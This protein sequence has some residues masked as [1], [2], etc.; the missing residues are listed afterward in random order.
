MI[1]KKY[2]DV[3]VPL[4]LDQTFV[5]EMPAR[6]EELWTPGMRVLVPF[7]RKRLTGY[8]LGDHPDKPGFKTREILELLDDHPLFPENQIPF[9]EWIA[10]YYIHPLGEVIKTA[11]PGG[12]DRRDVSCAFM[13]EKGERALGSGEAGPDEA[14]V[15]EQFKAREG[16]RLT[17]LSRSEIGPSVLSLV[18]KMEK[19]GWIE[20]SAILKKENVRAKQEKYILC[21][22]TEPDPSV[23]MSK[24]RREILNIV[25][26]SGEISLTGLRAK[27]PTAPKLIRPLEQAGLIKIELRRVFRDPLGDPVEPDVPPELTREQALVLEKV[28]ADRD[29]GF[30]PYV[31]AGVTGSGKTEVYMRLAARAVEQGKTAIVLVPEIALI[32]QTERRFRARFGERIAVIHSMLSPGERL[33]QWRKI[34]LGSVSIVIGARSAIFSPFENI[35]IIIVDEEHDSS[36]KQETGLR[37][38]ARDLALV[39]GKMNGCPVVLGSATPSVQSFQNAEAGRFVRLNLE[40]R[41]NSNPLPEIKLVD[42]KKYKDFRGSER[43]ITPELAKEIRACLEKGNQALIFLNRRGFATFPACNDCGTP[44]SCRFCD[45][46][47]TF[48]KGASHYKCHLCGFIQKIPAVCP[49]CGKPEIRDFGFGTEKIEDM[50][51]AMFPDARLARMDQDSTARKGSA[52]KLLKKIRNRTVDIIVG[53]QMLAKGHDFPSITLVGVVCADLSLNLPDFRAGERTFQLL[54]QVAGRAGRG[55]EPGKVIMQT[56]T[57]D[58]FIIEASKRQDFVE[59]FNN[60]APFRKALEYPPFSRMIQLKI[61]GKDP[62]KVQAHARTVAG[63]LNRLL[64]SGSKENE[65]RIMGPIEAAIPRISDRYRWQILVKGGSATRINHLVR[66]MKEDPGIKPVKDVR[67]NVD[68]DPYSLM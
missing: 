65:I 31:L 48:H 25:A 23:R 64:Q 42:L 35:G 24:K 2:I 44:L 8:L 22:N 45:V 56:Y 27:I 43:I 7:G 30:I 13:T 15:M 39:R 26:E 63:V 57:P 46:T 62:K 28:E 38:N 4:P 68:V 14:R 66:Q 1:H 29:K 21:S 41:V 17:R 67:I 34:C 19:K 60:E 5:Y 47:L 51:K 58:H 40:S 9:F 3:A 11:L 49:E 55:R 32:S 6:L 59:F 18:R 61:S 54:A 20:I 10:Q 50:L 52:L 16:I 36:Y 37:Y 53:T 33:D 12:L